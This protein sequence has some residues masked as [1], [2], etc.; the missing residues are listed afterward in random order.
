MNFA[1][2]KLNQFMPT[3]IFTGKPV[4]LHGHNDH[5][6]SRQGNHVQPVPLPRLDAAGEAELKAR[7]AIDADQVRR[8]FA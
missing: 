1:H 5:N 2:N 7:F 3:V 8:L 6:D 4:Y